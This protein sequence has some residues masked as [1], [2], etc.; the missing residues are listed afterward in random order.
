MA[1]GGLRLEVNGDGL[2]EWFLEMGWIIWALGTVVKRVILR[3]PFHDGEQHRPVA[4]LFYNGARDEWD[5]WAT[6]LNFP[7]STEWLVS[8]WVHRG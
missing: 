1:S 4:E 7:T 3:K 8:K 2:V 6:W 5:K